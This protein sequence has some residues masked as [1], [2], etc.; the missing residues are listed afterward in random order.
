V[1][2]Y[3]GLKEE[4]YVGDVEPDATILQKMGLTARPRTVVVL[5]TPPSRAA[6]HAAVNPLFD[7]VLRSLCAQ[8]ETVCL[9]LTRHPEQLA[10]IEQSW[11]RNCVV[12]REAT[13]SR[14]L[15]YAADA[16]VGAGGTMTREAA[17]MGIPTW[18]L[19]AGEVP[20]VDRGLERQGR[21]TRLAHPSELP[22]LGPRQAEP[23][24]PAEVRARGAAIERI[25]VDATLAAKTGLPREDRI[26][27]P[28]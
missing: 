7:A 8:D 6:Y 15:I 26:P 28:A 5:R 2:R 13:D 27:A 18:T 21:L 4:L 11:L 22:E 20:A 16:M 3:P 12:P 1:I 23:R 10:S 17:L 24:T 14:S 19:F 9:A 25:L